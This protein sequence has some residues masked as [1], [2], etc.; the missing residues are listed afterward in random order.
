[1]TVVTSIGSKPGS[2]R[3]SLNKSLALSFVF[4]ERVATAIDA[5]ASRR[6]VAGHFGV[7]MA[8]VMR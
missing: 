3:E 1:M 5:G 7:G 8:G 4:R 2:R 6:Q